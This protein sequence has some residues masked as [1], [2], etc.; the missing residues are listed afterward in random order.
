MIIHTARNS[1]L[2]IGY[3][4]R[5]AKSEL[6]LCENALSHRRCLMVRIMD[7]DLI[8]GSVRFLYGQAENRA[9]TDFVECTVSEEKLL[10]IFEYP[11]GQCL[12]EML[13][14]EYMGVAERL[15][16]VK[17]TLERIILQNLPP[18][19]AARCMRPGGVWVKRSGEVSFLYDVT[20]VERGT[21]FGMR[22]VS[23][24][25][26]GL[27]ERVFDGELKRETVPELKKFLIELHENLFS[28]YMEIYRRFC[29]VRL[30]FLELSQ[31]A[32]AMPNTWIFQLWDRVKKYFKPLKKLAALI[33]FIV[34]LAY[35]V[36]T[37]RTASEPAVS[38]NVLDQI[39]TLD[40]HR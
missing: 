10:A 7:Q 33:L 35:M 25:F 24:A 30:A 40:I 5:G 18:Y 22:E 15:D 39:G 36:W 19:F 12:K 3:M 8:H 20:G 34:A 13:P 1:Y 28:D 11:Q 16:I 21:D 27:L 37:I 32:F 26:G 29:E 4:E 2:M 6:C 31:E 9:F 23:A 14:S 38:M 17:N